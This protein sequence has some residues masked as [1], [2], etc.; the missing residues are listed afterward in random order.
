MKPRMRVLRTDKPSMNL[1]AISSVKLVD[2]ETADR[3]VTWLI[4]QTMSFQVLWLKTDE[5][6]PYLKEDGSRAFFSTPCLSADVGPLN[7]RL[8]T[9]DC[10]PQGTST[11]FLGKNLR[12]S[13]PFHANE[14]LVER[15]EEVVLKARIAPVQDV[16]KALMSCRD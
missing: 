15:L 14:S 10:H 4:G 6:F 2:Q 16:M 3:F 5:D 11:I 8:V 12:S 13:E 7:M 1:K 9:K